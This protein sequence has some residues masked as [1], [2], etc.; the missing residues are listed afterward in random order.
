MKKLLF[1]ALAMAAVNMTAQ[2]QVTC[3]ATLTVTPTRSIFAVPLS[4]TIAIRN[5]P[6][7]N[8]VRIVQANGAP[9]GGAIPIS[10]VVGS[11]DIT[12]SIPST[13]PAIPALPTNNEQPQALSLQVINSSVSPDP[14]SCTVTPATVTVRKLPT[15][16]LI[17]RDAANPPTYTAQVYAS[18]TIPAAGTVTFRANGQVLGTG[19][20]PLSATETDL[21]TRT[22]TYTP[23]S[24]LT[25]GTYSVTAEFDGD[26][27]LLKSRSD[28]SIL[29][30]GPD[31]TPDDF[32]FAQATDVA[33]GAVATS[34]QV[35][36]TGI[37]AATNVT[38]SGGTY[39]IAGAAFTNV[40]GTI[41]NGQTLRLQAPANCAAN[42]TTTVT[43]TVGD[44][45][46]TFTARTVASGGIGSSDTD[47]DGVPDS[48]ECANGTSI[49]TKDNNIFGQDQ[50]S[51]TRYVQQN[52]RDFLGREADTAGLDFWVG[53]INRGEAT[54]FDLL[55]SFI[56]S[57]E[58]QNAIKPTAFA[59]LDANMLTRTNESAAVFVYAA[60]RSLLGRN[61]DAAGYNFWYGQLNS[62]TQPLTAVLA[63]F[64]YASE[65]VGRFLV[66]GQPARC[67]G[68]VA[69][70]QAN[71][72]ARNAIGSQLSIPV[73]RTSNA[74]ACSVEA[75]LCTT[76]TCGTTATT[77]N[78]S[79]NGFSGTPPRQL[80][81][82]ADGQTTQS[83]PL[84]IINATAAT[85]SAVR[86]TLQ[87]PAWGGLAIGATNAATVNFQTAASGCEWGAGIDGACL[88]APRP[89]AG[90][91]RNCYSD[92][93]GP[94][95][96]YQIP[97][98]ANCPSDV[99]SAWQYN[100]SLPALQTDNAGNTVNYGQTKNFG[101]NPG[102]AISFRFV[103]NPRLFGN[104]SANNGAVES[105]RFISISES[106]CDFNATRAVQNDVCYTSDAGDL[107]STIAYEVSSTPVAGKCTL[108]PNTTYYINVRFQLARDTV[109]QGGVSRDD[110]AFRGQSVCSV[111]ISMGAALK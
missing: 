86:L 38:V 12:V 78:Y 95:N 97:R 53:R 87:N 39:S 24:A 59:F 34:S 85:T 25:A 102:Q 2:A 17:S 51:L 43:I 90:D 69:F 104:I 60:Y 4:A 31:N 109:A 83:V 73:T 62:A 63:E 61:P 7:A 98:P 40:S 48:I 41:T 1:A 57:A 91:P 84:T 80:V 79:A 3:T 101:M 76:T 36:I 50:A 70:G 26:I 110:C 94:C 6:G 108:K 72:E 65:Y 89:G 93:S 27:N 18:Q 16:T 103:T 56:L 32:S 23:S 19:P 5:A 82:F 77:A 64:Y 107:G 9:L 42:A 71:F 66:S 46:R 67:V 22:A 28:E 11:A 35:T 75:V 49:N 13:T 14:I 15:A 21:N 44:V 99:T 8:F 10:S 96:S 55:S 20:R 33:L 45:T 30:L 58:Y 105:G 74:G 52:Y 81:S 54:R 111:L 100:M 47:L 92:G 88:P 106:P 29:T 68:S 37:N